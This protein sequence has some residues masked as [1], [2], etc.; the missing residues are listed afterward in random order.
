MRLQVDC[1]I[2]FVYFDFALNLNFGEG[3]EN[4]AGGTICGVAATLEGAASFAGGV[5]RWRWRR[6][7]GGA[8]HRASKTG[9]RRATGRGAGERAHGPVQEAVAS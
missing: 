1:K 9:A 3:E 2:I 6:V 5:E 7:G 8:R 4:G